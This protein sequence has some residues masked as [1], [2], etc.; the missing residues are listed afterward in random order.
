MPK[1]RDAR[2]A[3]AVIRKALAAAVKPPKT[4]TTD[5]WRSYIPAIKELMPET[6][7][8]QSEGLRVE[9]NNNLSEQVQGTFRLMEKTL[10]GLDSKEIGQRYL[11]GW[12]LHYN[13]TCDHE[14]LGY[15]SPGA[16]AMVMAPF[17]EWAD[18][19]RAGTTTTILAIPKRRRNPKVKALKLEPAKASRKSAHAEPK[20]LPP[21]LLRR[22]PKA[23]QPKAARK[24][25]A[26]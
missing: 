10:R 4:F 17:T 26:A 19:V 13:L 12:V 23:I 5:K 1:E 16:K 3:K 6:T 18:V 25:K 15:A 2:A 14:S 20:L 9:I 8:M 22:M 21:G 7:Y 24:L 11:D